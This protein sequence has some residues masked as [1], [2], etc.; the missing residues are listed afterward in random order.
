MYLLPPQPMKGIKIASVQ[1]DDILAFHALHYVLI[2][3][4]SLPM[5]SISI[6]RFR[7]LIFWRVCREKFDVDINLLQIAMRGEK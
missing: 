4:A 5:S 3:F 2:K 1:N 7:N 6:S